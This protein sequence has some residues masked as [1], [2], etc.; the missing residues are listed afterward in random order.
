MTTT[1]ATTLG[2]SAD[3][4]PWTGWLRRQHGRVNHWHLGGR[5]WVT[6]RSVDPSCAGPHLP[7]LRADQAGRH[8]LHPAA[9]PGPID[10]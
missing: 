4:I 6:P 7:A 5:L 8:H 2:A 10:V 3:L 1:T 9:W